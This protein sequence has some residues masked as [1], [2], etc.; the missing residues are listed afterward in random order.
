MFLGY[1]SPKGYVGLDQVLYLPWE[2]TD[3]RARCR[4][5]GIPDEVP[6]RTKP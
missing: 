1:A 3:D 2:W 4:Q 6:F 5:A